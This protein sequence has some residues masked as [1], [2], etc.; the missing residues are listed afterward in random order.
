MHCDQKNTNT[1]NSESSDIFLLCLP[2][3]AP[4]NSNRDLT[5]KRNKLVSYAD[6][7]L[8]CHPAICIISVTENG[9]LQPDQ[10]FWV[11][12][13]GPHTGANLPSRVNGKLI[14]KEI[15]CGSLVSLCCT[16]FE[17]PQC[18]CPKEMAS[19]RW[20]LIKDGWAWMLPCCIKE[21]AFKPMWLKRYAGQV[22]APAGWLSSLVS[23]LTWLL[24][25]CLPFWSLPHGW[26]SCWHLDFDLLGQT[27]TSTLKQ[28]Y[29][30]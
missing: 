29:L 23:H 18:L 30:S 7:F 12:A 25:G 17:C 26:N 6:S 24:L 3:F 14:Q 16:G 4:L 15:V 9:V 10:F 1:Q 11:P 5:G 28:L 22:L 20:L 19:R 21:K 8:L 13:I 2:S 27:W